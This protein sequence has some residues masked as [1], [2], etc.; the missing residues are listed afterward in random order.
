A[1]QE[2]NVPKVYFE[3]MEE[4]TREM[5][6]P[7]DADV[8][9]DD[10]AEIMFTSG[11]TGDPKGVMLT[12]ANLVTNLEG[13]AEHVPG[14]PSNRLISVLPLSHM[15][16]QMAS[17]MSALNCGANITFPTS[18]QPTV[19]FRT[20]RERRVTTMLLVPQALDLIMKRIETEVS[21]RGKQRI[22]RFMLKIAAHTPF[23]LRR[24]LFRGVHKQF[25][26]SLNLIVSGG[27][28]LDA[29]LGAKW[30]ALGVKVIQA[31]GATE[32]SPTISC[33]TLKHPRFDSVGR[34]IPNV[35]VRISEEGEILV[36]GPNLT[37]G[38][39]NEPEKTAESF[40]DGWYKTGDLGFM[41]NEGFLHLRGR[42]KDMIVLPS[43]E[44]VFP[45]DIE[46]LLNK[47]PMTKDAVVVGLPKDSGVEVHA[48]LLLED[49]SAV[50]DVVSWAN[51]QLAEHQQIRG[52]TVW[53]DEDFPRTHTLKVKKGV[54]VDMIQGYASAAPAPIPASQETSASESRGLEHLIAEVC[55][56]PLEQVTP[57][58]ALGLDLNLDSLGR[59]ML[60]S[61]VEDELGVY[62]DESL[63]DSGTT[64]GQLGE[65][66][67][68][69]SGAAAGMTFPQWGMSLWCRLIRGAI[70][71]VLV[72]PMLRLTNRLQVKGLENLKDLPSPVL[73]AANHCLPLDN[74][75]I[76]KTMPAKLRRRL[77]IAA[78]AELMRNPVWAVFNPLLG[79]AFP[80]SREGNVRASLEN[81]GSILDRGWSV[82]I[83]PEGRLTIG[84]PMQPF[85]D[86]T[87][88]MAMEGNV[89]IVPLRLHIHRLGRPNRVTF[90]RRSDVEIR[91]G[92]PLTFPP[93]TPYTEVTRAI[94]E[95]VK[96][97]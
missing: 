87:G 77:A 86:G 16:E 73:F 62:L 13:T 28:A 3:E 58:K 8:A 34:P 39:W 70:Q 32:A 25:G 23:R 33:H 65:M 24:L 53:P 97:L 6:A 66:V 45:E 83:Y 81:L 49:S 20:M 35:D 36:R 30:S 37:P 57:E 68:S 60:L 40:E 44:N 89:P 80:F 18:R 94:E 38:Y 75:L 78:A 10:L 54:V 69:N 64:V 11:T 82:L 63:I 26:G 2:L 72:F 4:L 1:H 27:A 50:S 55:A 88:L 90:L 12:H 91:F 74:G 85:M 31:Y 47:H 51:R 21:R 14:N 56:V 42:K 9:D 67:Q 29:E 22:W 93:G 52:S 15:F 79:N 17:M 61:A 48:A 46:A 5:P 43:G 76:I 7:R 95:A 19:L 71:R 92:K 96:A 59:V 84:G 41:D